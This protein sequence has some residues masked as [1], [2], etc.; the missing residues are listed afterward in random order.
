M[1]FEIPYDARETDSRNPDD[2]I[3]WRLSASAVLPG[4]DFRCE[5]LIPVFKTETSDP[6]LTIAALDA[7]SQARHA[8]I[9]PA[10]SRIASGPSPSG[11]V[12]FYLPA[13]RHKGIA[14]ALTVFG[15][16]CLGSGLFFGY[17]LSQL[18]W[19]LGLIP[20]VVIGGA[21][22]LLL[23]IA[24]GLWF[25]ATTVEVVNREL[26][27]RTTYL[28]FG[29]PALESSARKRSRSFDL[30][31][32]MQRGDEMWYDLRVRLAN[33]RRR[34]ICGGMEKSEAEWFLGEIKKDMGI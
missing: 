19:V 16:L 18:S 32:G 29:F 15:L 25:G 11:G 9:K 7:Q 30:H 26:H 31:C 2:E 14:A 4:I 8:G 10:D 13:A 28:V 33:G 22:L 27:I 34:T 20:V 3:L 12:R 17:G 6:R 23:A 5:F 21:G 1:E 24:F